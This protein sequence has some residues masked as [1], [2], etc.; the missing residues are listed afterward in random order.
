MGLRR[1]F[2]LRLGLSVFPKEWWTF[3][4][5]T[6]IITAMSLMNKLLLCLMHLSGRTRH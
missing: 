5:L 4:F 2:C 3:P 6:N 1:G